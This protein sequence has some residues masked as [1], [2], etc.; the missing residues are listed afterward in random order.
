MTAELMEDTK[1][2]YV[3]Y[4]DE[5]FAEFYLKYGS[6]ESALANENLPIS[7]ADFHR[8]VVRKGLVKGDGQASKSFA[9]AL[10]VFLDRAKNPGK[11]LPKIFMEL[12]LTLR[13]NSLASIF[14]IYDHVLKR[15]ARRVA[16]GAVITPKGDNSRILLANELMGNHWSAKALGQATIPFG[17]GSKK[18]PFELNILRIL[19]RELSAKKAIDGELIVEKD[20]RLSEQARNLIPA[21]IKPFL[22]LQILDVGLSVVHIELPQEYCDLS[23]CSSYTVEKHR[24]EPVSAI[25]SD[26]YQ[27]DLRIGMSEVLSYYQDFVLNGGGEGVHATSQVNELL[28]AGAESGLI[29]GG[30][31]QKHVWY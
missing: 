15:T 29:A 7:V 8:R 3:E 24:F 5:W 11:S 31:P 12:P 2:G 30:V 25:L 14:R 20:G 13:D 27:G 21:N 4:S 6:V 1:R 26:D 9:Q 17:F 28:I 23:F 10:Y 18:L 22:E 19:Q 16:F